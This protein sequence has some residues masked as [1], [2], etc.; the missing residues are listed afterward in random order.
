MAVF[1]LSGCGLALCS[2][3]AFKPPEI[4]YDN[5]VP[6]LPAPPAVVDDKPRPLHVPP[7]WRPA[8]GGKSGA[9]EEA[10]PSDRVE[11]ANSAARVEPRK[12][13]YFNAAQVFAYSPGALYQIYDLC[14]AWAD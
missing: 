12:K 6:P 4:S 2:C 3:S 11:V 7:L 14:C 1:I 9:Q 5:D 13:G 10:E 8:F